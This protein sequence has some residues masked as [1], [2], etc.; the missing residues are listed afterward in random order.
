MWWSKLYL[1]LRIIKV[2]LRN[3]YLSFC[4]INFNSEKYLSKCL[5]SLL[6]QAEHEVL[7]EIIVVDDCSS[8]VD[9]EGNDCKSIIKKAQKI[10]KKVQIKYIHNSKNLG[11]VESRRVAIEKAKGEFIFFVDS[12]DTI[13]PYTLAKIIDY[14]K[15]TGADIIHSKYNSFIEVDNKIKIINSKK[16]KYNYEGEL[17]NNEIFEKGTVDIAF[18]CAVIGKMIRRECLINAYKNIPFVYCNINESALIH[19]FLLQ[20]VKKY[21]GISEALYNYRDDSGMTE[22]KEVC[23]LEDFEQ[24]CRIASIF[25]IIFNWCKTNPIPEKIL[26]SYQMDSVLFLENTIMKMRKCVPSHLQKEAR[27]LL[28][29]YWGQ[30]FV[31]RVEKSLGNEV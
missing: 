2:V 11:C 30:R 24:Y 18:S 9:S 3:V 8:G 28:N 4:V 7:Y 20:Q 6:I 14:Q 15:K 27:D 26:K 29:E 1:W 23:Y 19:F 25:S 22:S 16:N 21:V 31:E 17:D 13:V 12:D 5:E 10:N